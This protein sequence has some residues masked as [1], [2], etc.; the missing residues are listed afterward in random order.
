VRDYF[1][2]EEP[3]GILDIDTE[4]GEEK[5]L[6]QFLRLKIRPSFVIIEHQNDQHKINM[7]Q[8]LLQEEYRR[9]RREGV[10]DIWQLKSL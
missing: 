9:I 8:H 1:V 7:Q 2:E 6:G 3:I 10:N 4:G 5:I